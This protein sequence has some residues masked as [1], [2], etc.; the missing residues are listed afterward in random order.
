M[1]ENITKAW[2]RYTAGIEYKRRIG[3]YSAVREN[4]R[5]YRG[6]QWEGID[7]N[8]LPTPVFNI[9]KRIVSYM[10]STA[11]AQSVSVNYSDDALPTVQDDELKNRISNGIEL[12][13]KNASYRIDKDKLEV[14]LRQGMLD[15]ALSGDG[16]FYSFWD[17]DVKTGQPY[18]GDIKTVLCDNTE[19]FV[20]NVNSR[21]LQ[22]QAYVMLSGRDTV[23]NLKREAEANGVSRSDTEKITADEQDGANA[24]ELFDIESENEDRCTFLLTFSRDESGCVVWEKATK[25]VV[26]RTCK[27]NMQRYPVAYFSWENAKGSFIGNSPVSALIPNQKYINKAYAMVMKHM[28]DTAFSKVV[29]DKTLIPEWTN[30]VGQA[31]AVKGGDVRQA[32]SIIGVGDMQSGFLDVINLTMMHTKELMGATDAALGEVDPDNTSA[33]LALQESSN[34]PLEGIRQNLYSCV[35]D[36]ALNWVDMMFE[37]YP[38]D[39]LIPLSDDGTSDSMPDKETFKNSLIRARVDVGAGTKYSQILSVNTLD[40]LLTGGYIA[41]EDYLQRLPDGIINDKQGLIDKIKRKSDTAE[42]EGLNGE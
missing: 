39:R 25:S 42:T 15:A 16:V 31:I 32:A 35:E 36:I 10:I 9:I 30:E 2:E 6:E 11:M 3:L 12:L 4:E 14:L 18:T 24:G 7:S 5:F 37:Y 29:Y 17:P 21:D 33:I 22:A 20:S 1:N 23:D 38:S 41:I 8:G 13:N 27:T 40:K 28:T 19:L 26:I 34:I